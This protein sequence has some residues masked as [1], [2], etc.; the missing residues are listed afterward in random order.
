MV[1]K[2]KQGNEEWVVWS[3]RKASTR[4]SCVSLSDW[5]RKALEALYLQQ[6]LGGEAELHSTPN[7]DDQEC[8]GNLGEIDQ[9]FN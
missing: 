3:S 5:T 8:K 4:S 7:A 2:I 6:R 1:M 9:S